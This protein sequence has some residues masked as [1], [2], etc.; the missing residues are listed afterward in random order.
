MKSLILSRAANLGKFQRWW[1]FSVVALEY[2]SGN[3][4][5]VATENPPQISV[6]LRNKSKNTTGQY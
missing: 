6:F 4:Y 2:F 3:D 5:L 1:H